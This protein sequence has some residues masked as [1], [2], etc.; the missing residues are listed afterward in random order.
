MKRAPL[1]SLLAL[2]VVVLVGCDEDK[3][4]QELLARTSGPPDASLDAAVAAALA[5]SSAPATAAPKKDVICPTGA[6]LALTDPDLEAQIRLKL[7]KPKETLRTSDLANVKSLDLTK[8]K[9]LDELDPCIL[10]K[11]TGLKHLYLGPGKLRDLRPISTLVRLESLRASINEVE[12]LSPLEKLTQLDV[13]DLGRTHVRDLGPL[14]VLTNLTELQLDN[15]Q[16]ADLR[17]LAKMKKL[18]MLSIKNTIVTDVSPLKDLT[19]LKT[20]NV[21]GCAITNL[22][23]L[24]PLVGRGLRVVTAATK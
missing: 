8:K 3:K 5:M 24:Q 11:M 14:A 2:A 13:L 16:V 15:T 20:L 7:A 4:K 10:P 18:Q 21:E 23:A 9:A 1:M 22:D 12:D 17:P 6:D 19:D